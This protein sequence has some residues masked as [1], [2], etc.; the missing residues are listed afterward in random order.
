M[1]NSNITFAS[2]TPSS[3]TVGT[4]STEVI[5]ANI[6]N[7]F[8]FIRNMST[9][10]TLFISVGTPAEVNKGIPILPLESYEFGTTCLPSLGINGI[11]ASGTASVCTFV[12]R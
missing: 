8:M 10:A 5:A 4:S 1:A 6:D 11:V 9:T 7:R 2:G 12:G 3:V